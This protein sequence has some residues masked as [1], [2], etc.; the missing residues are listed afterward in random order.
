MTIAEF[1][2]E[3]T[4]LAQVCTDPEACNYDA[5]ATQDDGSCIVGGTGVVINILT[6]NYP[7][8]TT[9]SLT[10]VSGATIASGGP[11]VDAA[12]AIQEVVC[13]GDGCFH[14]YYLR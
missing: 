3:T 7:G 9:W 12:T 8:E 1:V 5:A 10:D 2:V 11:Y 14:I 13:V 6:D 4:H